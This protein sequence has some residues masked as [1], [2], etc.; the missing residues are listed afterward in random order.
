MSPGILSGVDCVAGFGV[1][2]E[3]RS[4]AADLTARLHDAGWASQVTVER[5][6]QE[7]DRSA[8][9]VS[10]YVMTI[11]D[12]TNDLTSSDALVSAHLPRPVRLVSGRGLPSQADSSHACD[13][14]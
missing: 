2:E 4:E 11:D 12:Y 1:P 7:W 5:L 6:L 10:E 3:H 13:P 14:L 8:G 9:E